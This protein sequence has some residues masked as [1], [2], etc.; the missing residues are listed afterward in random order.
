MTLE[1]WNT[2]FQWG[3]V[4]LV[5]L[6]FVFVAGAVWTSNLINERQGQRLETMEREFARL[7]SSFGQQQGRVAGSAPAPRAPRTLDSAARTRLLDALRQV[8][9]EGPL[10]IR[11]VSGGSNEPAAFARALADVIEEAGWPLGG[12]SSGAPIGEPPVGVLI[13]VSDRG[14]VPARAGALET[15]LTQAGIDA[16]IERLTT[17]DDGAVELMI[18]LQP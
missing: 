14:S 7:Q 12:D 6:T 4:A 1:S 5:A 9:P 8:R 18:G 13:R 3:A 2:V 15:A 17:V 10:E 11:F 16:R